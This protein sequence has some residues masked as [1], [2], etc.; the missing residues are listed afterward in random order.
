MTV[1]PLPV[2]V[3][4]LDLGANPCA[5]GPS[6]RHRLVVNLPGLRTLDGDALSDLDRELA[7]SFFQAADADAAEAEMLFGDDSAAAGASR[8]PTAPFVGSTRPGSSGAHK[9]QVLTLSDDHA[10]ALA[11]AS[12]SVASSGGT[13]SDITAAAYMNN[14]DSDAVL[15]TL[16]TQSV[17]LVE[18]Y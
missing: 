12:A 7:A 3:A 2:C 11:A 10:V 15:V 18:R 6:Y 16:W 9:A 4:Q 14:D 1:H 13:T 5:T 17:A 8:A